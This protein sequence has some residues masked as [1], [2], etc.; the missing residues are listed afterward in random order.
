MNIILNKTL[1]A[2]NVAVLID[3]AALLHQ[4]LML[5]NQCDL[6]FGSLGKNFFVCLVNN[7]CLYHCQHYLTP[8]VSH[9]ITKLRPVHSQF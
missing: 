2:F 1:A 7:Y 6:H 3:A 4:I 5:T 9:E 8:T